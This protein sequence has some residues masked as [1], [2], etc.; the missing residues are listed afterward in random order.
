MRGG[1]SNQHDKVQRA[2][3][4]VAQAVGD[5]ARR[6]GF[7]VAEFVPTTKAPKPP[8]PKN[9]AIGVLTLR[10]A[11]TRLGITTDEME[12]MVKRGEVR[13]V[14]V[15]WIVMVVSADVNNRADGSS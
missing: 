13:T 11:A 5:A 15:G 1:R 7:Q 12:A 3:A 4:V 2:R 8:Q 10:E 9:E 6:D 14:E